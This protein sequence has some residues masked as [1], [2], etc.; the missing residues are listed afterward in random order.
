MNIL[1]APDSFKGSLSA[2]A[3]GKAAAVGVKKVMDSAEVVIVPMADGGEGSI[4][5][6]RPFLQKEVAVG[7]EGPSGSPVETSYGVIEFE[8]R[9]TALVECARSTGLTL[10]DDEERHPYQLTSYGLGEQ[11]KDAVERGYR[12]IIVSL[13]GSATTDGGT[14]M[15]RAL[16]YTFIDFDGKPIRQGENPLGNIRSIDDSGR[17]SD[18]D[19]C[20]ITIASDVTNPFFGIDGAAHV[21]GPQKGATPEHV[22]E[23]DEGLKDLAAIV[24]AKYGVDLQEIPGAGAAG[25]LG[26]ALAGV[27][28]AQMKPGF[29]IIAELT[30]LEGKIKD[31]DVVLTGEGSLD[32]QSAHGKVPVSVG[33]MAKR[34]DKPV[35]AMAGKVDPTDFRPAIDAVYSIQRCPVSLEEAVDGEAASTNITFT[36]ENI[37]RT[38]ILS[39]L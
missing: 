21:Y 8:G 27:L 10:V 15:L 31:A 9:Y 32:A 35:I 20:R 14:G 36:V 38:I 37:M 12:D 33:V 18:L 16:G 4:D 29:D 34:F 5:A 24:E 39:P 30:G 17:L 7:V 1:I 28:G 13:G 2:E 22:M 25:G 26:G 19:D 11:I 23:L 6:L 3:V